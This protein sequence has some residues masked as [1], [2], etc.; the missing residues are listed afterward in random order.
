[1][2]ALA[3]FVLTLMAAALL[4]RARKHNAASLRRKA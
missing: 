1:V 3:L 4:W 2:A